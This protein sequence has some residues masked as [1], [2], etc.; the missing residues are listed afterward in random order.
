MSTITYFARGDSQTANNNSLNVSNTNQV[1]T[2]ELT[3]EA[4]G[5]DGD[6]SFDFNGG[7]PDPDTVVYV[8]GSE[9]P[10]TFTVEFRGNLPDSG[11]LRTVGDPPNTFDLRGAEVTVITL[12]TGE[13]LF[14]VSDPEFEGLIDFDVMDDF[15]NG[16]FQIDNLVVCFAAG[17]LI[18]TPNGR[19]AVETLKVGDQVVTETGLATIRLVSRR[20]VSAAEMCDSAALRPVVV[21]AGSLG[22]GVPS[23]DL[24][25]T[26]THRVKICDPGLEW[27]FGLNAAFVQA[28]DLPTARP[29]PIMETT[30]VH[31]LCDEHVVVDANGC[32]SESLF[33]GDMALM[34]LSPAERAAYFS[35]ASADHA[36]TAYPC[37]TAKEASV[38]RKVLQS[39][40]K[41]TA[42]VGVQ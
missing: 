40:E 7:E 33:P 36:Q 24:T 1:P 15:P 2:T 32:P 21:P 17:T 12:E 31:F 6:L 20:T 3:F 13:R 11:R 34:A 37:L 30:L 18:Q 9:T 28:K 4:F 39:R 41:R 27:M 5:D 8:D 10:I 42:C 22:K 35:I 23:R 25:L 29:G 14:F 26:G 19:C 38:W 16:A